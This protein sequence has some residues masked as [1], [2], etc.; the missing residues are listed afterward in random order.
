MSLQI[1]PEPE[2]EGVFVPVNFIGPRKKGKNVSIIDTF[3]GS[4][5][6]MIQ[7]SLS[8]LG[9]DDPGQIIL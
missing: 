3:L 2:R 4:S 8:H 5:N 1:L 7:A 6:L 9:I